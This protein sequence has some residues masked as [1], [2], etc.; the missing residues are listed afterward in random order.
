MYLWFVVIKFN[1]KYL[2]DLLLDQIKGKPK[3]DKYIVLKYKKTIKILQRMPD[4]EGLKFLNS[5]NFESLKGG[6]RGS[7]SVRVDYRYRLIFRVINEVITLSELIII[8]ELTN[9]YQ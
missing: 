5:L 7:Y 2:E 4:L 1:D 8:D 6:R 3:F 9:H